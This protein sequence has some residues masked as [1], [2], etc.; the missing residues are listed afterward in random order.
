MSQLQALELMT[1]SSGVKTITEN[2]HHEGYSSSV[3]FNLDLMEQTASQDGSI[4]ANWLLPELVADVQQ[5]AKQNLAL[6]CI[7]QL[8]QEYSNWA[9]AQQSSARRLSSI[10]E[11]GESSSSTEVESET[12]EEPEKKIEEGVEVLKNTFSLDSSAI[13]AG[14]CCSTFKAG[15]FFVFSGTLDKVQGDHFFRSVDCAINLCR[16]FHILLN[17]E[18]SEILNPGCVWREFF[19]ILLFIISSVHLLMTGRDVGFKSSPLVYLL[20]PATCTAR[21]I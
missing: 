20:S 9:V 19:F 4:R 13:V 14:V 17:F 8:V 21:R 11:G 18:F 10:H 12:V 2:G 6:E 5:V 7:S 16:Y 3:G 15:D 1:A